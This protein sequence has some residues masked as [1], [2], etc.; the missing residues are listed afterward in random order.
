MMQAQATA[1]YSIFLL[2]EAPLSRAGSLP[3]GICSGMQS[4]KHPKNCGSGL[5][6][7]SG[8]S[9]RI[10]AGCADAF[11]SKPAPTQTRSHRSAAM[12]SRH[13]QAICLCGAAMASRNAR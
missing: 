7:E 13:E 11:A 6:R 2:A 5:A 12:P 4:R 8:L 9:V 10:D 3:Q 1:A